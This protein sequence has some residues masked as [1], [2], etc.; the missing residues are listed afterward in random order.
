MQ[1]NAVVERG[2]LSILRLG[3]K[4]TQLLLD[5]WE[6]RAEQSVERG[7]RWSLCVWLAADV[8]VLKAKGSRWEPED[9]GAW[10][11]QSAWAAV[12]TGT[13]F[14]SRKWLPQAGV[15]RRVPPMTSLACQSARAGSTIT[16]VEQYS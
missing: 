12:A 14:W 2:G 9:A 1:C 13:C 4:L 5:D 10:C 15:G 3:L 8:N 16:T 6:S 7:T 11:M